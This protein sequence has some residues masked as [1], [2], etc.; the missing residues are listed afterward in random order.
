M[1]TYSYTKPLSEM[2]HEFR[3]YG[4]LVNAR[5][6]V[7]RTWWNVPTKY[8]IQVGLS[9][10]NDFIDFMATT[11]VDMDIECERDYNGALR[12]WFKHDI[13]YSTVTK[14]NWAAV[15]E[16]MTDAAK[17]NAIL[18]ARN[19]AINTA[20]NYAVKAKK[21]FMDFIRAHFF[22]ARVMRE[23]QGP[24]EYTTQG[25]AP[26]A[27]ARYVDTN[28]NPC[29]AVMPGPNGPEPMSSDIPF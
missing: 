17:V 28:G 25:Y 22:E 12:V 21:M 13:D 8:S 26:P 15:A 16:W 7:V 29:E 18:Y 27:E 19:E 20:A 23:M 9:R 2:N 11:G 5:A 14:A 4:V 1:K 24:A 3:L 10:R 6:G